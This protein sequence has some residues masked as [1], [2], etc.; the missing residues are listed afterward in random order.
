MKGGINM[1]LGTMSAKHYETIR[2]QAE[3]FIKGLRA[4][5]DEKADAIANLVKNAAIMEDMMRA[6]HEEHPKTA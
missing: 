5:P 3:I 1:M 2:E 6:Y 4:L